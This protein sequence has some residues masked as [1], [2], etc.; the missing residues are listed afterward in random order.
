[1]ASDIENYLVA[2]PDAKLRT[3]LQPQLEIVHSS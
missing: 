1:M 2:L 3:L